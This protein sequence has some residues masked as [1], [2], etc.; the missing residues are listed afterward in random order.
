M[1]Y[2]L[3]KVILFVAH[4]LVYVSL[5]GAYSGMV[6]KILSPCKLTMTNLVPRVLS[7][8]SRKKDCLSEQEREHWKRGWT[9]TVK[10]M[11]SRVVKGT[12]LYTEALWRLK[13]VQKV[14]SISFNLAVTLPVVDNAFDQSGQDK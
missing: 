11:T 3:V 12:W 1:E 5:N 13:G 2:F 8:A 4:F 6:S 10:L 7:L 14:R 9:M